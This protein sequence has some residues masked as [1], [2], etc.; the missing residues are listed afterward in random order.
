MYSFHAFRRGF[1][2]ADGLM[3]STSKKT[4]SVEVS[5][6]IGKT[7]KTNE[8]TNEKTSQKSY[9]KKTNVEGN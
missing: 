1:L 2:R 9:Q 3:V 5:M 6:S 8:K 7:K 4:V